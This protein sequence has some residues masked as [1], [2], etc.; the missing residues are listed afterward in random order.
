MT[1]IGPATMIGR[2]Y[3][4]GGL[5]STWSWRWS[6]SRRVGEPSVAAVGPFK[7]LDQCNDDDWAGDADWAGDDGWAG[8]DD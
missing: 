8:D 3:D 2:R 1:M 4:V 7:R 5:K 6:G